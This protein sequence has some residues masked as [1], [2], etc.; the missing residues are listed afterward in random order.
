MPA[1]NSA[2]KIRIDESG[3]PTD[4]ARRIEAEAEQEAERIEVPASGDGREERAQ[5]TKKKSLPR[6]QIVK[7]VFRRRLAAPC[8]SKGAIN[9]N[10]DRHV[11]DRDNQQKGCG[12]T[13]SYQ[14]AYAL[15]PV[16]LCLQR[17]DGKR[18]KQ[19]RDDDDGRMSEGKEETGRDRLLSFLHQL[20]RDVV[21]GSDVIGIHGMPKAERVGQRSGPEQQWLF[22]E[23]HEGPDPGE[24]VCANQDGVKEDD[25]RFGR[26][27]FV[28]EDAQG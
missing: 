28:V 25:L 1:V 6:K 21:D 12:D 11:H 19:V 2:G 23:L 20:S 13:R 24:N 18:H 9:R 26:A 17:A 3:K 22:P 7:R 8:G 4:L 16:E 10:Q 14:S 27:G 5:D 15:E